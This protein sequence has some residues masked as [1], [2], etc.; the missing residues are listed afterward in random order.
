M[1]AG[2]QLCRQGYAR[3]A[4]TNLERREPRAETLCLRIGVG[5]RHPA[6]MP[7]VTIKSKTRVVASSDALLKRPGFILKQCLTE[8]SR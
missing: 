5:G 7:S 4:L 1:W 3:P 8:M 6:Q 2:M